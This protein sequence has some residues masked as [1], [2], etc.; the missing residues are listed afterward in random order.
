MLPQ[1]KAAAVVVE[2]SEVR[3]YFSS[4]DFS[5]EE[6]PKK[7][8]NR[9]GNAEVTHAEVTHVVATPPAPE[10]VQCA[11]ADDNCSSS[12]DEVSLSS[13][14]FASTV[15]PQYA[16]SPQQQQN[17]AATLPLQSGVRVPV[18]IKQQ[19]AAA[20]VRSSSMRIPTSISSVGLSSLDSSSV[21]SVSAEDEE[22]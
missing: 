7:G 6:V 5:D 1:T 3:S 20:E 18:D 13:L 21:G 2:N 17:R 4:M 12:S 19:Q 9:N 16:T 15:P 14:D 22:E 10:Q 8:S 11:P